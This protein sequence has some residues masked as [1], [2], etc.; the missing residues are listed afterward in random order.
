MTLSL[1]AAPLLTQPGDAEEAWGEEGGVA[2]CRGDRQPAACPAGL[3]G[4]Q[5]QSCEC[6]HVIRIPLGSAVEVVLADQGEPE[7]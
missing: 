5:D 3:L 7:P 6:T 2:V 4:R 1:P